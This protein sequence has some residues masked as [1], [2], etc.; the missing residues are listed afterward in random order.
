MTSSYNLKCQDSKNNASLSW[1]F[2]V[3]RKHFPVF[4]LHSYGRL[5]ATTLLFV[6]STY[7][8]WMCMYARVVTLYVFAFDQYTKL[9]EH[10]SYHEHRFPVAL[11]RRRSNSLIDL[12][13]EIEKG[14]VVL[15]QYTGDQCWYT[16]I[17]IQTFGKQYKWRGSI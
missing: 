14:I 8:N 16:R 3:G 7:L 6:V 12:S 1:I 9:Y 2:N 10:S 13:N 15:L 5:Q 4:S 17:Q 11:I